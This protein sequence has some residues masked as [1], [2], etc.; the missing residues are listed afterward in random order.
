MFFSTFVCSLC[1][2]FPSA[3]SFLLTWPRLCVCAW[4]VEPSQNNHKNAL[5][6]RL[7]SHQHL[8]EKV[9]EPEKQRHD[10]GG[11]VISWRFDCI[12]SLSR[13]LQE[14]QKKRISYS[15]CSP[16]RHSNFTTLNLVL[17]TKN[18]NKCLWMCKIFFHFSRR[19]VKLFVDYEYV[20]RSGRVEGHLS[21]SESREIYC[22]INVH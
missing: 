14:T 1:L 2:A 13:F 22:N 15:H 18:D 6:Q 7:A 12:C 17:H 16:P 4:V 19:I 3:I 10:G 5:T 21:G 8:I 11:I 20:S 9:S